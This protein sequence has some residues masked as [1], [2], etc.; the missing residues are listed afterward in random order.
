MNLAS[1]RLPWV[2]AYQKKVAQASLVGSVLCNILMVMRAAMLTG[3]SD[4][5]TAGSEH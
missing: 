1:S 3:G 5:G 4:W 2:R